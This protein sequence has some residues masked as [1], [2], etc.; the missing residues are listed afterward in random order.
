MKDFFLYQSRLLQIPHLI[1]Q[2]L[3][4]ISLTSGAKGSNSLATREMMQVT[5]NPPVVEHV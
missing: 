2:I 5:A 4:L 1:L 3:V